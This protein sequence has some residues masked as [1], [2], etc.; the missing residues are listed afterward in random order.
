MTRRTAAEFDPRLL[1]LFDGYVHGAMTRREF[2]DR[3]AGL[4]G[5]AGATAALAALAPD[6]ARAAE[7]GPDDPAIETRREE[8]PSPGGHGR[9]EGLLAKPAG[10]TGRLPAALVVHE[11][12]GLN[13]YVEDVAR[14]LA[15]AGYLAFA[16][17]GL[18]TLGGY[19]GDDDR[20]REM[21]ARLDP[22]KL[23]EDFFAAFD[24]LLAH[25]ESTGKVG[26]VGFCWGGGVCNLLAVARPDLAAAVP[27]YGRQAAA[28]DVPAIRAPL[29]LH[30]AETDP[31]INAGWPAFEMAL[32]AHGKTY[33]AHLYQ[34][35]QHGFHNDTTP[36]YDAEAARLS[37]ERTLAFF[38]LHLA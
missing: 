7:V 18:T 23:T 8:A 17:D 22:V 21:Q 27:Y 9:I 28:E 37:W 3:A 35:T 31:R 14:R 20:G 1:A 26:A 13:P 12:R 19:P 32:R 24:H 6:Y 38:A 11:N 16:P 36:R 4:V 10:A 15:K 2:L 34:G 5:A 33:E 25:A 30:F 29:L